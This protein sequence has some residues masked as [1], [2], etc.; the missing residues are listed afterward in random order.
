VS[1]DPTVLETLHCEL[2]DKLT[3]FT[4]S[5]E[6]LGWL[7]GAAR[8]HRFSAHNRLL[9]QLQGA[10]G[11]HCASY[12]RWQH[13]PDV[14]GNPCQVRKDARGLTILAPLTVTRREVDDTTGEEVAAVGIRGFRPVTVFHEGQLVAAPAQLDPPRPA[15]LT[16]ADRWQHVWS[17]VIGHLDDDGYTVALHTAGPGETWNG[18]T[19]FA[20]GEI[21][22]MDHLDP[23]QRIKTLLHEWAHVALGHADAHQGRSREIREI[24]AESVAYLVCTTLGLDSSRYSIPYLAGWSGG[25]GELAVA[26]AE[27]VLVTT[28]ELVETLEAR[29]EV[30]LTADLHTVTAGN[31]PSSTGTVGAAAGPVTF[32][33][34]DDRVDQAPAGLHPLLG[35][36]DPP[37][38]PELLAAAASID[39]PDA[40]TVAVGLCADAGLDAVTTAATLCGLGADR[41]MVRR[42]M[43][44]MV[45]DDEG[46]LRPLFDGIDDAF[47]SLAP[48]DTQSALPEVQDEDIDTAPGC[49]ARVRP[50][51]DSLE[52]LR[53]RVGE[54]EMLLRRVVDEAR[55]PERIAALAGGLGMTYSETVTACAAIGLDAELTA[56]I[57]ITRRG[58]NVTLAAADL[59]DGWTASPP[60]EGWAAHLE[61]ATPT[62]KRYVDR[63]D[64]GA[65]RAILAQWADAGATP[66]APTMR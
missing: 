19:Q 56:R 30:D 13:I 59:A 38:R 35:R 43:E 45:R 15:L 29:L 64:H 46:R 31:H 25:D 16:G 62:E 17:A 60:L 58:G 34:R 37:D 65:A 18:R 12:R 2:C 55:D 3:E 14:N 28:A 22:V 63:P 27:R 5:D 1:S 20:D 66:V 48:T 42:A 53:Y 32:D 57:A 24:E 54:H 23:P 51:G 36:L 11:R 6:W 8:L 61:A 52:L 10:D 41:A 4:S 7:Q 21:E 44:Q 47:G 50:G 49:D 26:T 39:E 33:D 9:L 40:V